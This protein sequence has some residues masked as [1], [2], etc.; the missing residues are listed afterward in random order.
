MYTT[1]KE[2]KYVPKS[3]KQVIIQTRGNAKPP[4]GWREE[5]GAMHVGRGMYAVRY[6][7]IENPS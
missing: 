1:R 6:S 3:I 2:L 4:R 7:R 5:P